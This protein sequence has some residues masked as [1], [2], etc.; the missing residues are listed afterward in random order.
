MPDLGEEAGSLSLGVLAAGG[1]VDDV[2]YLGALAEQVHQARLADP[3]PTAEQQGPAAL[4]AATLAH[5]GE[6]AVQRGQL[7]IAAYE[8]WHGSPL[9]T[10]ALLVLCILK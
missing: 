6:V 10:R 7:G 9:F 2:R 4:I 5:P 3:A 8:A 1:L